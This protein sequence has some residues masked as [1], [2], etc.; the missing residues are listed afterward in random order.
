MA[1]TFLV[2]LCFLGLALLS[3]SVADKP[4]VIFALGISLILA[5]CIVRTPVVGTYMSAAIAILFDTL[6]SAYSSTPLSTLGIF[7]NLNYLGLPDSLVVS[8]FEV[9]LTLSLVSALFQRFHA[10]KKLR[11]GPLFRPLL[12]F[13]ACVVIGEILGIMGGGDFKTSLWEIRPL[14]YLLLLYVLAVNTI[15]EGK[16][17]RILLWLTLVCVGIRCIE[18][19][20]RYVQMSPATR[21][22]ASTVLD[23]DDSL[24]M[25]I[26]F[27]LLLA[28]IIWRRWLPKQLLPW[29]IVLLPAV[30]YMIVIN[31]RR[32]AYLCIFLLLATCLPLL[33]VSL[34]SQ[35]QRSRFVGALVV[36]MLLGSLY[37]GAFWNSNGGLGA[38]AQAVKSMIQPDER[39]FDSNLYR[40]QENA[41]L[42]YTIG[43]SPIIG[44]GFG[45]P[46][47]VNTPMVDLTS[48][49]PLQLYMPH[50]NVLWLWMRMGII[51]FI[52]F[53]VAI[54]AAFLLIARA[55]RLGAGRLRELIAERQ[56]LIMKLP[57]ARGIAPTAVP[58]EGL[59]L[60]RLRPGA[61]KG[62]LKQEPVERQAAVKVEKLLKTLRVDMRECA[63]FLTLNILAMSILASLLA[64]TLVDQGLMS[65]R[66][67]SYTGVILGT[68]AAGWNM[69]SVKYKPQEEYVEEELPRQELKPQ[70]AGMWS[71]L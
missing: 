13:G 59:P 47:E 36:G 6:P 31:H 28:A 62:M 10:R 56:E 49:W 5:V 63:E 64:A 23:H 45:R 19:I 69:Y 46:M 25:V 20:N 53:W 48:S 70:V 15:R 1:V 7:R 37:L 55:T 18:G 34:R 42:E 60:V 27:A 57:E 21:A 12:A 4:E 11:Q 14:M 8:L 9:V 68:L 51:G 52:I 39:D 67:S 58:V 65:F 29:L 30:G 24:F 61:R 50:N 2:L 40:D 26:P 41:N 35:Q 43:F 66:L 71:E 3:E 17:I 54:G 32:A 44:I 16:Q 38:P 33:W 22:I